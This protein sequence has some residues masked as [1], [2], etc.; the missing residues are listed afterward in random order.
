MALIIF[1]G[2]SGI[3]KEIINKYS[4]DEDRLVLNIDLLPYVKSNVCNINGDITDTAFTKAVIEK[5]KSIDSLDVI[6]WSIRYRPKEDKVSSISDAMDVELN[7]LVSIIENI[8]PEIVNSATSVVVLSSVAAKLVS[9]QKSE[10]NIVKAATEAYVRSM[11]VKFG[12]TSAARFNCLQPGV[13]V[14]P[15]RMPRSYDN[16][17]RKIVE[18]CSIPKLNPVTVSEIAEAVLFLA[19]KSSSAFNGATLAADGGE[20]ILDQHFVA[21]LTYEECSKLLANDGL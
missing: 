8:E 20:S 3:G 6:I 14:I 2:S 19:S 21:G 1:G 7:P 5:L 12:R 9:A 16:N 11:A 18:K 4:P 17:K 13:V 15:D 10:Y